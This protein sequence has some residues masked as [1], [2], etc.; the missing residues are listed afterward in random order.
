MKKILGILAI[1]G[2]LTA[3]SNSSNTTEAK[4]DSVDSAAKVQTQMVDSSAKST[5]NAIDSTKDVAKD[6]LNK[7]DSSK[8]K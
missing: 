3:C 5:K 7:V 8:K 2:A 6:S 1:A 4:K